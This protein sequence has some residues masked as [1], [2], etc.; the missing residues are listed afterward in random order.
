MSSEKTLGVIAVIS[1]FY[2]KI[3]MAACTVYV[4]NLPEKNGNGFVKCMVHRINGGVYFIFNVHPK[5][6]IQVI[7]LPIEYLEKSAMV[8]KNNDE[9]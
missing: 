3:S 9:V 8:T 7:I 6:L 2:M 4:I 5:P 1:C